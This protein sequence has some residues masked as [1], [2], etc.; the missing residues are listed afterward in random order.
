MRT[1]ERAL[2][3]PQQQD[4]RSEPV[5]PEGRV[6]PDG[7]FFVLDGNRFPFRGV[8][9]GTFRPRRDGARFPERHQAKRDLAAMRE[10]GFTVLRTYTAPPD[11][12]V[13][14]AADWRLRVVVGVFY[15]D[16]RY[17]VGASRRQ[18]RRAMRDAGEEVRT[19]AR[20]FAGNEHVMALSLGN[21]VPADAIRWY[22]TKT[23][24]RAIAELAEVAREEDPD[25]LVTYANYPTAEYLPLD[26]LDFLTFNVFLE[27]QAAF[28]RYLTRLHHLAGDRPL[29]LGEVGLHS[30]AGASGERAQAGAL[31]WML[32]TAVERGVGGT[33]VFSWT[34]EWCVGDTPVE[35]WRFG[36]T[37]VDRSP[38]PALAVAEAWNH[39]TVRNLRQDWPRISVV[40]CAY[41]AAA[42][43]GE[44]L[45]HT[46][47]LDYPDLEVI[48]VDDGSTDDTSNIAR[49]HPRARVIEMPHAG[50]SAARNEGFRV[51]TGELVA[52][53]D[54]DAYPSPEWPYYL[55]LGLDDDR[56]GGVGGPNI[57]P[58]EA[59]LGAH[60]V[61]RAPG[62]PVHVLT[63]DD[64]AEHIPGC[65]M[66]FRRDVL[67]EVAGFDPIYTSAGDDVD[68]CW[69]VL[70]RGWEL[71]FHPAALVWH[72]RRAGVRAYLRQQ[73]G[74]GRSEAL[75]EARHPDRFTATG[76]ARWRGRIYDSISPGTTRQHVYRGL[77]GAAAYQS[78]YQGGG[79]AI[80][81]AHQV[82][83]PVAFAW[84]LSAPLAIFDWKL[85][86]PG[87]AALLFLATLAIIDV[88]GAQAPRGLRGT[89][90]R[91]RAGVAAMHLLQPLVRTWGRWRHREL[92]RRDLPPSEPLPGPVQHVGRGVLLLPEDR[93][94]AE[95][96][97][98]VVSDLRRAGLRVLQATGWE[99]HDARIV[100][101][102]TVRGD[103]VTSAH[104]AGTVQLRVRPGLRLGPLAAWAALVLGGLLVGPLIA[105][106]IVA[107]GIGDTGRGIYAVRRRVRDVVQCAA[108]GVDPVT[109]AQ[110]GA[111][112]P[113]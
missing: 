9:Y 15:Q 35:G 77:Y 40:I 47:R 112:G 73:R 3:T 84:V 101:S 86:V 72:H 67:V 29:V 68:L 48:V 107:A 58:V 105:A 65:N 80:D 70:D 5:R 1:V 64:R 60:Q 2:A 10:R 50:L 21:E 96:A 42:T 28:R 99:A 102:T 11:D 18:T 22:G 61:A 110:S 71:G 8:T 37:R 7:K 43:I 54:S 34:D 82:G 12:I 16:W 111:A 104:L 26:T 81:L 113:R 49:R 32:K 63:A 30:G 78:V 4:R 79:Y 6:R 39:R 59:V 89:G 92:A 46:C 93:S 17:L 98:A 41:N 24:S 25:Q 38:K 13:E 36:L 44:C 95:L 53:L 52:Y 103:L 108:G 33:C 106:I 27:R 31:D 88:A 109:L 56:L 69:R 23:V 90:L 83:V 57:P 62:G 97:S 14:L 100:G 85:G 20:R 75:V 91:F 19:A 87:A 94:R 74:Y 66:A 45:T 55:A 76:T 51:A